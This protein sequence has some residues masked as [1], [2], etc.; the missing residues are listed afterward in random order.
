MEYINL[1]RT[2]RDELREIN[3]TLRSVMESQELREALQARVIESLRNETNLSEKIAAGY[4]DISNHTDSELIRSTRE[5]E[6]YKGQRN[7]FAGSTG[8]LVVVLILMII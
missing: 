5:A 8:V 7:M 1:I 4:T 3:R 6:R 2:E